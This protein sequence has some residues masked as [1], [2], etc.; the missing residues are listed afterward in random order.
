MLHDL[1]EAR[2][3]ELRIGEEGLEGIDDGGGHVGALQRLQPLRR[4]AG[5]HDL[6]QLFVED[7]DVGEPRLQRLEARIAEHIRPSRDLEE[8]PPVRVRVRHHREVAVLGLKGR[9]QRARM[10]L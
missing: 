9:R 10:R 8:R 2:R 1:P 4:V 5:G 3:L 7:L 6:A